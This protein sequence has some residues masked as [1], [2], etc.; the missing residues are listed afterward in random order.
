MQTIIDGIAC[1][2]I[3]LG[4]GR[5]DCHCS[6]GKHSASLALLMDSGELERDDGPGLTVPNPTIERIEEWALDNGY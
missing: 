5:K 3:E 6:K 2:L 4:D 1:E